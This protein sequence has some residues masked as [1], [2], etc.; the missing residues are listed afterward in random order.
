MGREERAL[1]TFLEVLLKAAVQML[2]FTRFPVQIF[3]S[4]NQLHTVTVYMSLREYVQCI[5]SL[6]S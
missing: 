1:M 6:L 3:L 5:D 2:P 4:F